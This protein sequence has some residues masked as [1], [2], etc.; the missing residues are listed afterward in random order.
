M[1]IDNNKNSSHLLR[2]YFLPVSCVL[3]SNLTGTSRLFN[4]C[5]TDAHRDYITESH[6]YPLDSFMKQT[7]KS[8]AHISLCLG[9]WVLGA[10]VGSLG[11]LIFKVRLPFSYNSD[12]SRPHLTNSYTQTLAVVEWGVEGK[13]VD[14]MEAVIHFR[15]NIAGAGHRPVPILIKATEVSILPAQDSATA[16]HLTSNFCNIVCQ[17]SS[18]AST[19][20]AAR[21][22]E[23]GLHFWRCMVNGK[24]YW[25]DISR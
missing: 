14:L 15:P 12:F 23:R 4:K 19:R 25:Q 10:V 16:P 9:H 21:M 8:R 17:E 11:T 18:C 22:R 24:K 7:L 20:F 1:V 6:Q 5:Q 13:A 3:A 2:A